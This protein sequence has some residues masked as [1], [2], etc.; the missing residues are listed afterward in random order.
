M[1]DTLRI[2]ELKIEKI[3]EKHNELAYTINDLSIAWGEGIITAEEYQSKSEYV[4]IQ[5]KGYRKIVDKL[6][7]EQYKALSKS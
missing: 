1:D 7:W 3:L 6:Y 5:I 4:M 2:I